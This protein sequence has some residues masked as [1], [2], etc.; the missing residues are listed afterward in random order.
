MAWGGVTA[1]Q[2]VAA[3]RRSEAQ[4]LASLGQLLDERS[5]A[6]ELAAS[7]AGVIEAA[8]ETE[9]PLA[10]TH[11]ALAAAHAD[12]TTELA[13]LLDRG[14]P[15]S[16][17]MAQSRLLV[18]DVRQ[19]MAR[20]DEHSRAVVDHG[21]SVRTA[22]PLASEASLIALDEAVA[23]LAVV[24]QG[25]PRSYSGRAAL[26]ADVLTAAVAA[27]ESH[28]A[29]KAEQDRLAAERAATEAARGSGGSSNALGSFRDQ[30]KAERIAAGCTLLSETPTELVWDCP[31]EYWDNLYSN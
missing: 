2:A 22:S 31:P 25:L 19:L 9:S 21:R 20:L 16:M 4:R 23:S 30:M 3:E 26:V 15:I 17:I 5:A 24:P 11:D 6:T 27:T 7:T 29:V 13:R 12:L 1:A 18:G 14:T 28:A 8:G 10:E